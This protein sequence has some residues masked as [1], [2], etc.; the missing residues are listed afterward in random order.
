VYLDNTPLSPRRRTPSH[1]IRSVRF[2][3]SRSL[4]CHML[5][6]RSMTPMSSSHKQRSGSCT[7]ILC[8]STS[9]PCTLLSPN[10]KNRKIKSDQH[11]FL[12]GFPSTSPITFSVLP[13]IVSTTFSVL[14]RGFLTVVV[15][16]V[17]VGLVTRPARGWDVFAF[18]VFLGRSADWTAW[19]TRGLE[20]PDRRKGLVGPDMGSENEGKGW[21][22]VYSTP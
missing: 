17:V 15:L 8:A 1:G 9:T 6:S 13:T 10:N 18:V 14:V 12:P 16:V 21:P 20:F 19:T 11:T 5:A 2:P 7:P 22:K 3:G 4:C